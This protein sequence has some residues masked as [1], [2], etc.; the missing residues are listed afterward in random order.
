MAIVLLAAVYFFP[1]INRAHRWIRL[2]PIG[3]QPSELAKVAFVL[4]LARY[5]M[6]RENYR[7]LRGL[8]AP[9]ALTLVP[10]LLILKEP[11]LGTA[12]VFLP[13]LFRDALCRR[14]Q[15]QRPGLRGAGGPAWCCRCCGR[16]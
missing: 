3:L 6:Y 12:L 2:G 14:G 16:R 9:L 8:L 15:T 10:V 5:L 7:R 11:D 4:A 13:V 1:P